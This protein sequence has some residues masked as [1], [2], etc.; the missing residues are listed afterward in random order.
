MATSGFARAIERVFI[1]HNVVDVQPFARRD[2]LRKRITY[3]T[4]ARDLLS[5]RTVGFNR[6]SDVPAV[7]A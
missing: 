2:R 6:T 7:V 5:A 1:Q 3:P 4:S